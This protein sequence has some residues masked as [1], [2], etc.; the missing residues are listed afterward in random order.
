[1]SAGNGVCNT[2]YGNQAAA[3]V[4]DAWSTFQGYANQAFNLANAQVNN[5]GDFTVDYHT[6]DASFSVDPTLSGFQRPTR[7]T[8][9]AITTPDNITVP[10][11]P[12]IS[13]SEVTLEAAPV[14]PADL[15]NPPTLNLDIERPADLALDFPTSPTLAFPDAP[16]EPTLA[17]PDAPELVSPTLPTVPSITIEEFSEELADFTAAPP[18]ATIDFVES[19]YVSAMLDAV[20]SHLTTL[21]EGQALPPEVEA[22]LFGRAM[23]REERLTRKALQEAD[24]DFA[25]RGFGPEP[26]GLAAARRDAIRQEA[27]SRLSGVNRDIYVQ[28]Q[29][30]AI[31]NVRFAVTSGIQLEGTLIQAHMQVEQRKFELAKALKDIAIAVFQAQVTQYNAVVNA[32]NARVQAYNAFLEGQ[33]ARVEI[34]KAQVEA[35]KVEGE[36]NEQQVRSYEA[37]VRAEGVRAEVYRN[38]VDGFRA[39]I[40]AERTRIEAFGAQVEAYKTA[41]EAHKVEWDA[42]KTRIEAEAKRGELYGLMVGAYANRVEIWKTR[43]EARLQTHRTNLLNAQALLQQHEAQVRATLGRLQATET[44][45]RAQ[46]AQGDQLVRMYQA[47]AGLESTA[48]DAD[49]R[50]FNAQVAAENQ[51]LEVLLKDAQLQITQINNQAS[52]LL[53]AMETAAQVSSQLAASSMSAVNY[54][55]GV[56]SGQSYGESCNT[57]FS[58]SGEIADAGL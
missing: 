19:P 17:F 16:T 28:N 39:R 8:L 9:P 48:V 25:R 44:L 29:Q 57:S 51:R 1:M 58:Y 53:R 12:N 54:S 18:S 56:S 49:T 50:V 22:A 36:I 42:E 5:L 26:S 38:Q 35:A 30:V 52:L 40:E 33:K 47:D 41:V 31:E 45:I 10:D 14:E 21:M 43:Q 27:R 7:P 4:V 11:A 15:L 32:F 37:R 46:T 6:W 3:L 34:Y 24:E 13:L 2:I 23:D 20:K 55:A